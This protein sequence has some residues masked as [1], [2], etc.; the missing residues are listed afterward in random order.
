MTVRNPLSPSDGLLPL[1]LRPTSNRV[2][3]AGTHAPNLTLV[4]FAPFRKP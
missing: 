4:N 2:A 1:A 3:E